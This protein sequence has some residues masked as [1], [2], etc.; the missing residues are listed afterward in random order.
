MAQRVEPQTNG[1][2]DAPVVYEKAPDRKHVPPARVYLQP[3]APPVTLGLWGFFGSTFVIS[4]WIL[5]WWGNPASPTYFFVFNAAFGG[6]AQFLA[7][8]VSFKA[9]DYVASALLTMWGTF[10]M[11]YGLMAALQAD[12]VIPTPAPTAPNV[13]FAVWFIPLGL[14]TAWGAIAALSPSVG[15]IPLF[16]LLATVGTGSFVFCAGLWL[17]SPGWKDIGAWLFIIGAGWAWYVG[18]MAML[19]HAWGRVILPLGRVRPLKAN[20]PGARLGRPG[21]EY[22]YGQPGVHRGQ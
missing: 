3:I 6:V 19:E 17:G 9:R 14:F 16:F 2:P 21:I 7:G 4:T 20:I 22:L 5:G 10:W 11:A 1:M 12:K 18:A 8:L 15:N 13:G